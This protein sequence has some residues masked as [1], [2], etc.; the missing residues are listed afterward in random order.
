MGRLTGNR[1]WCDDAVSI[2]LTMTSPL[3]DPTKGLY[4]H[5]WD[6]SDPS[7]PRFYW[8]RATGWTVLAMCDLLDV[9]P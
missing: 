7:A 9:L 4:L 2:V 3:F 8:G 5:G 1:A 6:A